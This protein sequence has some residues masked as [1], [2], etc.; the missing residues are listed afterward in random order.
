MKKC[1]YCNREINTNYLIKQKDLKSIKCPY[2]TKELK[3]NKTSK[4]F[5][6]SVLILISSLIFILPL[7]H[8]IKIITIIIWISLFGNFLRPIIYYYE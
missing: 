4:L 5:A 6:D 8:I 3:V 1:V 2:C 7:I